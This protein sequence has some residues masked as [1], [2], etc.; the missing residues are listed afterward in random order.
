[1]EPF[2][3]H[4]LGCGSAKPTN[5]HFPSAQVVEVRGK[6]FMVDCGEGAQLQ[7]RKAKVRFSKLSHIF[8]THLHGD[9]C[10]GLIGLICSFGLSGRIAPLHV[11][12]PADMRPMLDM[13]LAMYGGGLGY[14]VAFHAVDCSRQQT[15][16]EDKSVTV[17][18]IPLDHR[19]PC[20]GYLFREKPTLPHIR[21]DMI[22]FLQIPLC[23]INRIKGGGDWVTAEGKVV[24]HEQLVTP[25]DPV[26]SYAYCSDT[27]YMPHLHEMVEGVDLLYHESTYGEECKH[28]AQARAHSTA[29]EAATVARDAHVRQLLIGHYSSRYDNE[30][31]LLEEARNIFP[32][33]ILATE[34]LE[35]EVGT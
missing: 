18:N 13:Q 27:C 35:V 34:G 17:T 12:A 25:A 7:L 14:E 11:Y 23:E 30:Q 16:F 4:V 19:M 33:T 6:V 2:V 21:R 31:V 5:R 22:D 8:I 24:P 20:S 28:L 29:A 10:F 32:N 1:M 15:I 9:H 26:R 3:V